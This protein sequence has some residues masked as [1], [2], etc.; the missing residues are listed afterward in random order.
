ML[1]PHMLWASGVSAMQQL[2]S[3]VQRGSFSIPDTL[4][5]VVIAL[6]V[7]G[8]K[9]LPEMSRQLGKLLFEFRRASNDFKLQIEEELRIAE[10]AERQ[11][12]L[13]TQ[14]ATPAPA[15]PVAISA[16]E[17]V[18]AEDVAQ[19]AVSPV[20]EQAEPTIMPPTIQPP[21]SGAPVSTAP[22]NRYREPEPAAP[23]ATP[24]ATLDQLLAE[25]RAESATEPA[26]GQPSTAAYD[27]G[28]EAAPVHHG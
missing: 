22:P 23:E 3:E 18:S 10:Q 27:Q 9:K 24:S 21:S 25:A 12:Q 13:V 1:L 4:F 2:P 5:L 20:E 7:F 15:T 14:A 19:A 8:P 28:G 6:I 11:K 17:T 26:R 16:E